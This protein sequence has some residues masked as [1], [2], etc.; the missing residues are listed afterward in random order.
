MEDKE[1]AQEIK[2]LKVLIRDMTEKQARLES[3]Q[4]NLDTKLNHLINKSK[5]LKEELD[6]VKER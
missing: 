6:K 4:N 3:F 1:N 5:T 2:V